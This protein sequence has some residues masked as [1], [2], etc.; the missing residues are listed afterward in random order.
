MCLLSDTTRFRNMAIATLRWISFATFALLAFSPTSAF[1]GIDNTHHDIRQYFPEK[2]ACLTC[3]SRKGPSYYGAMPD[4]LGAVGGQ[5]VFLCHSGKGLLPETEAL[6][7]TPGP[8][9]RTNGAEYRVESLPDYTSVFFTRS[10]GR[11]AANLKGADGRPVPWPPAGLSWPGVASGAKLE[12]TSCHSVHDNADPPFLLTSLVSQVG[13]RNGLCNACHRDRSTNDLSRAP[14]GNHPVDFVIDPVAA[15][16]RSGNG[17][18]PRRIS[19]QSYASNPVFDVPTPSPTAL[20]EVRNSWAMGG[21]LGTAPRRAMNQYGRSSSQ[22]IGCY[23]CHSAHR[24]N[25]NGETNLTVVRNADVENGWSPLCVG[26]HGTATTLE[27]D[28]YDWNVGGTP[29]GHPAGAGTRWNP[30]NN[31]YTTSV[32]NLQFKIAEVK[33]INP[34]NG[35]TFGR[36]GEL[37]CTTCH[38]IHFGESDTN[39]LVNIGQGT[40]S[41]CKSCH[42]GKGIPNEN[43]WSKGGSVK[44]GHNTPNSHHVTSMKVNYETFLPLNEETTPLFISSPSWTNTKSGLGDITTG[45]DCADCHIFNKTAHNW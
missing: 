21:H 27:G 16:L 4:E 28:K 45:M 6:V 9:V 11:D 13:E 42:S 35:N 12:C 31:I 36:R 26:C 41:I 39:A 24:S 37:L 40:R 29:W 33:F 10:H 1:A 44:D 38:K 2:D 17:R 8:S 23:T 5:C 7:P 20:K 14:D 3:H 25:A 15:G 22:Q 32:A 30:T 34:Q 19:L 43:D 18:L